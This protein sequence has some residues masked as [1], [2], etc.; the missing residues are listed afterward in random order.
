M[1]SNQVINTNYG[2]VRDY[3]S[4]KDF[5]DIVG[6]STNALRYYD[7]EGI[8]HPA[9]RGTG[10]KCKHRLY[11]PTQITAVNMLRVM[12][13]ID[14][15]LK[16][17]KELAQNRSPESMLKL[18]SKQRYN[19]FDKLQ[20]LQDAYAV[21]E[22]YIE[23]LITGLSAT[24]NEITIS[25][26]PEIRISLGDV[27]DFTDSFMFYREFNKFCHTHKEPNLNLAYPI[28]GFF[29][30]MDAF[31]DHPSQPT[32]FF[33]LDPQGHDHKE[34]GL[35]L[36]GYTRGYYGETNDLPER[37]ASYA[38]ENRLTFTGSVYNIYLF[39]EVSVNDPKQFLLQ[40]TAE[41]SKTQTAPPHFPQNI[42]R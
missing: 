42:S 35:Y 27:N 34:S 16:T 22:T 17:V 11:E 14:I 26:M 13:E 10:E 20:L 19:L 40:V 41:V 18:L 15:P 29:E 25:E 7:K 37:M 24:E 1:R 3:I 5:A 9:T 23:L 30:S 39:D 6:I 28:G 2:I 31:I 38:N 21:V 32:R 8:F 12:A 36:V 4:I 33:S